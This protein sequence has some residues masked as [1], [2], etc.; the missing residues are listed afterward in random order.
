MKYY[1]ILKQGEQAENE[2]DIMKVRDEEVRQFVI[3]YASK[4]VLCAEGLME[5]IIEFEEILRAKKGK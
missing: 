1:I 2:F 4:I 3:V 5:A